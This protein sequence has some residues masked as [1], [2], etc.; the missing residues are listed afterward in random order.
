MGGTDASVA[1]GRRTA[2]LRVDVLNLGAV[3]LTVAGRS[4]SFSAV[5]IRFVEPSGAEVAPQRRITVDV[6]VEAACDSP[7]AL[8]VPPLQV[9]SPDGFVRDVVLDGTAPALADLCAAG[10]NGTAELV[11]GAAVPAG[12]E[13]ADLVD[14][15]RFRIAVESPSG[16]TTRVVG[17]RASGLVLDADPLP[18]TVDGTRRFLWLE[19]PETCDASVLRAGPPRYVD[20]DVDAGSGQT[21]SV[22]ISLGDDF[23]AWLLAGPCG[24][25]AP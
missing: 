20:L 21:A 22:R 16:R 15:D 4:D 17:V 10:M 19:R 11:R 18:A 6:V 13:V 23:A 2:A 24:E 7:Q 12:N 5:R 25:A 1:E 3:P 9:T 14:G 8:R